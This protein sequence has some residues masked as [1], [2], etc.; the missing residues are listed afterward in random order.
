MAEPQGGVTV[1]GAG[2]VYV[3][4]DPIQVQPKANQGCSR[5]T[6]QG[7]SCFRQR[8]KKKRKNSSPISPPQ[9]PTLTGLTTNGCGGPDTEN[10]YF[11]AFKLHYLEA[12]GPPPL[13]CEPPPAVAPEILQQYAATVRTESATV[14][15]QINPHFWSDTTYYVEYGTGECAAGGCPNTAPVTTVQLT[16]KVVNKA[17]TSKGVFLSGLAPGTTYRYRFVAQSSGGGPVHGIDPDGSGDEEEASLEEG[18]EGVFTTFRAPTSNPPCANDGFRVGP[19]SEL[20]DCRAYEM[21]SPIDKSNG[22]AALL[23]PTLVAHEL[24]KSSTSGDRFTY[25]SLTPFA[26]PESAPYLSQYLASRDPSSGWSSESISPPRS[27]R[28]LDLQFT[29]N[30]EF[31]AF[32]PD[33][34]MGWLRHNSTMPLSDDAVA[35]FPNLYRRDNCS[36]PPGYEALTTAPPSNRPADL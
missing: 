3:I 1:D 2:N 15:A 35:G 29:V 8:Q 19:G 24:N 23:P 32:T 18:L 33:L 27:T 17:I 16:D 31:K 28:P 13:A 25:F 5:L 12:Y 21:V 7:T 10:L 11:T 9:G 6:Q 34:C 26:E 14:R 4:E 30:N 36:E 22:D 20:P